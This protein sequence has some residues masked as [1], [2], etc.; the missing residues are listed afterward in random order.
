MQRTNT[1]VETQIQGEAENDR[2]AEVGRLTLGDK[3]FNL[4][5]RNY[6]VCRWL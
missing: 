4:K 3:E 1:M 5:N 2:N 6:S